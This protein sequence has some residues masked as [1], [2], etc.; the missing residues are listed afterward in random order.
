MIIRDS[1]FIISQKKFSENL[2][3]INIL[4]K[5]NGLIKGLSRIQK[6]KKFILFENVEFNLRLKNLDNL[7]FFNIETNYNLFDFNEEFLS[8]LIKASIAEL[9]TMFLP[10]NEQNVD[11]Y[12]DVTKIFHYLSENASLDVLEKCKEYILFEVRF[13]DNIGYGLSYS[14]CVVTG[15]TKNLKYISPKTGCAVTGDE[16]K[17]YKSKLFILPSFFLS[18]KCLLDSIELNEGFRITTHFL[19]KAKN[20]MSINNNKKMIFREEI[21]NKLNE[22]P[23]F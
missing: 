20:G 6:K 3:L 13:L 15:S 10:T 9:C 17:P 4:S 8:L 7:G 5:N 18:K 2:I 16:G 11:I 12:N 19:N 14:K 21:L 23:K 22:R 1:G